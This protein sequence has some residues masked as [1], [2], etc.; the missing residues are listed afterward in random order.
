M[1]KDRLYITNAGPDIM[2]QV[3]KIIDQF[4]ALIYLRRCT[5]E[6]SSVASARATVKN[7]GKR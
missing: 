4:C 2:L 6:T 1:R 7:T 5:H 3:N